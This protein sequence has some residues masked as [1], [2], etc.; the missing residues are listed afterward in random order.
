MKLRIFK[1]FKARLPRQQIEQ[2]FR[3]VVRGEAEKGCRSDI[4]LIFTGDAGIRGLNRQYRDKDKVT[5]VLSFV[6]DGPASDGETFGEIY[7]SV[8]AVRRQA[9]SY[10]VTQTEEYLR[11]VG[12]GLLHLFGYD[13][14][15]P[16]E[17]ARMRQR[18]QRYLDSAG[19]PRR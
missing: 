13:H 5:D 16:E 8:P 4:N 9:R 18:E 7:I 1:D 12:H 2:L 17:A 15:A 3:E 19:G 14:M 10:G 11:L 6:I